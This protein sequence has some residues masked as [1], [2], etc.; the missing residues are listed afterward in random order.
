MG[1]LFEKAI[2]KTVQR[3]AE[4]KKLLHKSHFGFHAHHSTALQYTRLAD[5]VTLNFNNSMSTAV[6]FLDITKAFGTTCTLSCYINFPNYIF[7]LA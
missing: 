5:H 1:K 2:L 7:W 3:Y 6:I 4:E